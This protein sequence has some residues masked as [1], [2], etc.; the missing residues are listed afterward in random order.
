MNTYGAGDKGVLHWGQMHL[1]LDINTLVLKMKTL[2][3]CIRT[4]A[5]RTQLAT[6]DFQTELC[7]MIATHRYLPLRMGGITLSYSSL[8]IGGNYHAL[9]LTSEY[10]T[11]TSYICAIV[12][13]V[14]LNGLPLD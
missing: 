7:K 5:T 10:T 12:F 11:Q 6:A 8:K 1:A 9:V 14:G 3:T 2:K 13:S 4:S